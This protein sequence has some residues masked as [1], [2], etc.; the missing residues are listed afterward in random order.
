MVDITAFGVM[1]YSVFCSAR[2]YIYE[3]LT[4]HIKIAYDFWVSIVSLEQP[5]IIRQR[6]D[7][8]Y[9][10]QRTSFGCI[11]TKK[12]CLNDLQNYKSSVIS[13]DLTDLFF[14]LLTSLIFII[15]VSILTTKV[16]ITFEYDAYRSPSKIQ[17]ICL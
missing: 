1:T 13:E 17:C 14:G 8:Y 2:T 9:C 4:K 3:L 16:T 15:G 5:L 6:L 10:Q 12:P 11:P 7:A